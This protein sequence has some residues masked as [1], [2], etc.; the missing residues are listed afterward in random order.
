MAE[1]MAVAIATKVSEGTCRST[2]RDNNPARKSNSKEASSSLTMIPESKLGIREEAAPDS[3]KSECQT[4]ES[5]FDFR[6]MLQQAIAK[7]FNKIMDGLMKII[8]EGN[9]AG[10]KVLF[11]ALA[12]LKADPGK[13]EHQSE[14]GAIL[15]D[16]LGPDFEW[17][18]AQGPDKDKPDETANVGLGGREPQ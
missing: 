6:L 16:L 17:N 7:N 11:D 14:V 18:E 10:A 1:E 4:A 2:T 8:D 5:N 13:I 12:K 15:S 3:S 9:P